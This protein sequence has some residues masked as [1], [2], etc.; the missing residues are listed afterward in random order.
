M[1]SK[2]I[3]CYTIRD[4]L[5]YTGTDTKLI[6]NIVNRQYHTNIDTS[7]IYKTNSLRLIKYKI[8]IGKLI[9]T[10]GRFGLICQYCD[11]EIIQL[12]ISNGVNYWNDGLQGACMG[13]HMDIIQLMINQGANNWDEGFYY[14][15]ERGYTDIIQLMINKG[16][17]ECTWCNKSI[18]E[19]KK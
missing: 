2:N 4:I 7:D 8:A 16:A 18:E 11:I 3:D 9:I 14:A 5:S 15:C 10:E 17:T 13:G 19:H 1:A 12:I 6:M